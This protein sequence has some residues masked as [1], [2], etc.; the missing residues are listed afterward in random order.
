MG[1]FIN[2]KV[3]LAYFRWNLF[4]QLSK[5]IPSNDRVIESIKRKSLNSFT[6]TVY[7]FSDHFKDFHSFLKSG[8]YSKVLT[9]NTAISYIHKT[10]IK[11]TNIMWICNKETRTV[12]MALFM[13]YLFFF[14]LILWLVGCADVYLG[15]HHPPFIGVACMMELFAK[16]INDF[17]CLIAINYFRKNF[18]HTYDW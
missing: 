8:K 2:K 15:P 5:S 9:N 11:D 13:T 17:W 14:L 16:L 7:R 18:H 4:F 6:W 12:P 1:S 3:F 10:D